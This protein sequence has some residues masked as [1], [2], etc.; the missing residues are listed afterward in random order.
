MDKAIGL[1]YEWCSHQDVMTSS[2]T[3]EK[4]VSF[5]K[6]YLLFLTMINA[7]QEE[8]DDKVWNAFDD[9]SVKG[10]EI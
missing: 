3:N 10:W 6:G 2:Q 4:N 1:A 7:T 5:G 8:V 9:I